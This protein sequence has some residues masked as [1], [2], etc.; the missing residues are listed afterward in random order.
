MQNNTRYLKT[1]LITRIITNVASRCRNIT[2][3]LR[4]SRDTIGKEGTKHALFHAEQ[5]IRAPHSVYD[6]MFTITGRRE[7]T[8]L[9]GEKFFTA[10]DKSPAT[11]E[12]PRVF[13]GNVQHR[14]EEV[15]LRAREFVARLRRERNIHRARLEQ[16][17]S[18]LTCVY[19]LMIPEPD[20]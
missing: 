6:F 5:A 13:N 8:T 9:A 1:G 3:F 2:L 14:R 10:C 19:A 4:F 12:R 18:A 16:Q 15:E 20:T 7:E 11:Y 17:A